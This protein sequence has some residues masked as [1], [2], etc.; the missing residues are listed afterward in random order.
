MPGK[1]GSPDR[2]TEIDR[3]QRML[4]DLGGLDAAT[5]DLVRPL[6][7]EAAWTEQRLADARRLIG[8]SDIVVPYDNGGGQEGV[9][10]NPAY[11][12]YSALAKTYVAYLKQIETMTG[13]QVSGDDE[14]TS[15]LA[16]QRRDSPL[17]R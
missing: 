17:A 15:P 11:D 14:A 3:A 8:T 2:L 7:I 9:R 10:R 12:G 5:V 4:R 16:R 6:V 1:R 13:A